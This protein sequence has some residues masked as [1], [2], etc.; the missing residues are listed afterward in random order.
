MNLFTQIENA[1]N[2]NPHGWTSVSKGQA[3]A[4]AI[5]TLRPRYSVELGVYAG[6]GLVTL[7]LAHKEIG[8][9]IAIGVDPYSAQVSAEGQLN[10]NDHKFWSTLDHEMIY[11]WANAEVAKHGVGDFV[12]LIRKRSNEWTP[13]DGIGVLR[14]DANH[15]ESVLTDVRLYC[16]KV[17]RGGVLFL[18][19]MDWT[20]GYVRQA[21]KIL[22]D[23][24]WREL[25]RI[26]DGAAFQKL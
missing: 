21:A 2:G 1:I 16:P 7:G 3:M 23:T 22:R 19:D 18:D 25:Y 13:P 17:E 14:I 11:G 10:P 4:A 24:G 9:G 8:F 12:K 15:G 20:G 5:L 6:K 26:D